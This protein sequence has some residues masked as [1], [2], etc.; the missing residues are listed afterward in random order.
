MNHND[1]FL[2]ITHA[3]DPSGRDPVTIIA[4]CYYE[5]IE[6]R[7]KLPEETTITT[8]TTTSIS[9]KG[10]TDD[11]IVDDDTSAS[12]SNRAAKRSRIESPVVVE[13]V[14]Q[15]RPNFSPYV[16]TSDNNEIITRTKVK[17][18]DIIIY[19]SIDLKLDSE[20]TI[21]YSEDIIM[22]ER[23]EFHMAKLTEIF[24]DLF[25]EIIGYL[26]IVEAH[27]FLI[28]VINDITTTMGRGMIDAYAALRELSLLYFAIGDIVNRKE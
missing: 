18:G 23:N 8:T 24:Q 25:K 7:S 6:S 16:N 28:N 4:R 15:P 19:T 20:S 11:V 2:I 10:D 26:D 3:D 9:T 14:A 13:E 22:P 27:L 17:H 12:A 1:R 5:I 21:N